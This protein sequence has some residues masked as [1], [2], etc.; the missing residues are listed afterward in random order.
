MV[1]HLIQVHMKKL[2][3]KQL[4]MHFFSKYGGYK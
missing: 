4:A 3:L 1:F 2:F